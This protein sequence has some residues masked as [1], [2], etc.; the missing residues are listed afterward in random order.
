NEER[1]P[2]AILAA[3]IHSGVRERTAL[4]GNHWAGVIARPVFAG[5]LEPDFVQRGWR[6]NRVQAGA[7]GVGEVTFDGVGAAA[8]LLDVERSIRLVGVFEVVAD[9]EEIVGIDV[10]IDLAQRG[11]AVVETRNRAVLIGVVEFR[12]EKIYQGRVDAVGIVLFG[13]REEL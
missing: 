8:P 1:L 12:G 9:G 4:A 6:N 5:E 3:E 2:E 10:P 13:L 11:D 7:D